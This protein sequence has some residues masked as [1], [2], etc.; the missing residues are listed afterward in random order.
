MYSWRTFLLDKMA[1]WSKALR[2]GRSL[3]RR[4]FESHSCHFQV[5]WDG[6]VLRSGDVLI[7][8][9]KF[10]GTELAQTE[11]GRATGEESDIIASI[12]RRRSIQD[13]HRRR[14][15]QSVIQSRTCRTRSGATALDQS[16]RRTEAKKKTEN[17]YPD[18]PWRRKSNR[19]SRRA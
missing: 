7:G 19:R 4:G 9:A 8:A 15:G 16:R 12:H 13:N 1:E 6:P 2:S 3:P 11:S 14:S 18:K 17:F 10:T 5:A